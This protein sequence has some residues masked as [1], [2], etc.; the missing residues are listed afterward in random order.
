VVCRTDRFPPLFGEIGPSS[1]VAPLV[2][3]KELTANRIRALR[4]ES[5]LTTVE[6]AKRA[7]T[8]N[9][10]IGRLERCERRLTQEWM[11][12]LGDALGREPWEL[13]CEIPRLT[14]E[15][16]SALD[17]LRTLAPETRRT[18]LEH[19]RHLARIARAE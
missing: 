3:G 18:L 5:G 16:R 11:R 15:E 19:L 6:L 1:R 17:D 12:R 9:Q 8:S 2:R 7:G 10:Q 14:D 13:L 4:L